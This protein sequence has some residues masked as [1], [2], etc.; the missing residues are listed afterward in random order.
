MNLK[1]KKIKWSTWKS[2]LFHIHRILFTVCVNTNTHLNV[3]TSPHTLPKSQRHEKWIFLLLKNSGGEKKNTKWGKFKLMTKSK[4]WKMS[5][6]ALDV[7]KK[8]KTWKTVYLLFGF[9]VLFF[10]CKSTDRLIFSFSFFN[11]KIL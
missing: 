5:Q 9:S 7:R 1:L 4:T 2:R 10:C 3:N 6:Y 11:N 8:K